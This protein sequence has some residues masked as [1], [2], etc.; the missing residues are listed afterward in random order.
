MNYYTYPGVKKDIMMEVVNGQK[1]A[2]PEY[3]VKTV[4]DYFQINET[5][6]AKKTRKREVVY[7]RKIAMYFLKKYTFQTL[8]TIGER[9]G[10]R[11]HTTVIH[12]LS[13]LQDEMDTDERVSAEVSYI[14]R[15]IL[16]A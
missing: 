10:R 4:C 7:K 16:C 14:E 3:V 11:D 8:K 5:E 12:S 1:I 13:S 15:K 2:D 6:I 9:F